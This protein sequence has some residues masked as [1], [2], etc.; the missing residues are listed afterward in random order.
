MA[1]ACQG[2]RTLSAFAPAGDHQH[3]TKI[4]T[5]PWH[6][7]RSG[8]LCRL[9]RGTGQVCRPVRTLADPGRPVPPLW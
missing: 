2:L 6:F 3:G 9:H 7:G 4:H 8:L 1:A 5:S